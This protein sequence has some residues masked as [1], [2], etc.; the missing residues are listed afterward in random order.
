MLV[1]RWLLDAKV[2]DFL[3]A[4]LPEEE[5]LTEEERGIVLEIFPDA[6]WP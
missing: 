3:A 5:C 6:E 1:E 4:R 2:V